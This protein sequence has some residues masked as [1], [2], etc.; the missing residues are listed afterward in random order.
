MTRKVKKG[1]IVEFGCSVV[2]IKDNK[3]AYLFRSPLKNDW[4]NE[5]GR[6]LAEMGHKGPII[7][8][9]GEH[10]LLS[11]NYSIKAKEK[12]MKLAALAE[13][14]EAIRES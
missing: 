2:C 8:T 4:P 6:A 9:L 7:S 10:S 5:I 12:D 11:L 1:L 3:G 14:A 13:Q